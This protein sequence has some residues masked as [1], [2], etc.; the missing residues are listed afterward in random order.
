VIVTVAYDSQEPL[1][2]LAADVARQTRAPERWLVV[3]NAPR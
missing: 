3:D 1:E 2:R